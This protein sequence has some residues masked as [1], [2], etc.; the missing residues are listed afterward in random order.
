VEIQA[1]V[2]KALRA[3]EYAYAPYSGFRVGAALLTSEDEVFT[4]CNV[5]NISYGATCCAERTAIFKAVSE[6]KKKFKAI[7]IASDL[8]DMIYPCGICRQVIVEFKIPIVIVSNPLGQYIE[9]KSQDLLPYAFNS[10]N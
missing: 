6:G 1:L 9:Y 4:G 10:I 7:A 2:E 3:R 5:E 8:K